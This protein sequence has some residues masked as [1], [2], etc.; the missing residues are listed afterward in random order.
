[1]QTPRGGTRARWPT[2]A[3]APPRRTAATTAAGGDRRSTRTAILGAEVLLADRGFDRVSVR[4]I[5][6]SVRRAALL[7]PLA[8][9]RMRPPPRCEG[10]RRGTE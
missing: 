2:A 10:R 3:A 5:T 8:Q 7:P 1:M 6:G 4:D 9:P